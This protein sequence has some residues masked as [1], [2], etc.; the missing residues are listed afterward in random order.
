[1]FSDKWPDVV[2]EFVGNEMDPCRILGLQR[3]AERKLKD[4]ITQS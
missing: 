4:V 2:T 1:M 3:K